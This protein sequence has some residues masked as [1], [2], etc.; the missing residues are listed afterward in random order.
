MDKPVEALGDCSVPLCIHM[1]Q[2]HIAPL[3]LAKITGKFHRVGPFFQKAADGAGVRILL[4]VPGTV[5][6]HADG[7]PVLEK[8]L[9]DGLKEL[10]PFL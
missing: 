2:P 5:A 1:G 3:E 7:V 6:G 4:V 9:A 8:N 10:V